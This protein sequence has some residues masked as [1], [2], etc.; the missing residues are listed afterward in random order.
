MGEFSFFVKKM[1]TFFIEPMGIVVSLFLL[2]LLFLYTNRYRYAKIT[3]SSSFIV[4]LLFSSPFISNYLV[5]TLEDKYPK[6]DYKTEVKYI[7]VLGG[8][9]N[10]DKTQPI[11]SHL[12]DASTKRVLEGIIIHKNIP[13]SIIIFTGYAG[14]TEIDTATM[15]AQLAIALG[16]LEKNMI[17]N[18]DPKDTKEEAIF[19]KTIVKE[20][21]FIL[22]SSAS[23]LPRAV[24]LFQQLGMNPIPAPTYFKKRDVYTYL[25]STGSLELSRMAVHEYIG[26][27]W[28]KITAK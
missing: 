25:P 20:E 6:F 22:V 15:N 23:H 19:T 3:L 13:N 12:S 8:G 27:L 1:I 14:K 5:T 7:H 21:P 11:S 18:G 10:T 4:L 17:V 16:V 28:A 2:G 24:T 9:H 26:T